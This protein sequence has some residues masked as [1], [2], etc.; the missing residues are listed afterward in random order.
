[1]SKQCS[2]YRPEEMEVRRRQIRTIRWVWYDSP[3]KIDN[4]LH[5]LRT[6]M[7]PGRSICRSS[8]LLLAFSRG[9]PWKRLNVFGI[10][11]YINIFWLAMFWWLLGEIFFIVCLLFI[12]RL[13]NS[14]CKLGLDTLVWHL[15]LHQVLTLLMSVEHQLLWQL[16]EL[17]SSLVVLLGCLY[18]VFGM[19]QFVG[20]LVVLYMSQILVL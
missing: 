15:F 12:W 3:A 5:G 6:G 19:Y 1:M 10:G 8:N 13:W 20:P 4:V 7:E 16:I 2:F 11:S 9:I 17:L 18:L 14:F